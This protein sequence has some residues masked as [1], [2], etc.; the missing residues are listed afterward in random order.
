MN[1]DKIEIIFYQI[2]YLGLRFY[3]N[4]IKFT[5]LIKDIS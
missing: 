2:L 1:Y 5:F 4:R 3:L